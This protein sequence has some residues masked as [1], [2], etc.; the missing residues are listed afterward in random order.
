MSL[1]GPSLGAAVFG[2]P[3]IAILLAVGRLVSS[4]AV[5]TVGGRP[6]AAGEVLVGLGNSPDLARLRADADAE[7]DEFV[8]NGRVWHARSRSKNVQTLIAQL[9]RRR[10]VTYAEPNYLL[11]TTLQ[12]ND[13]QF[14]SLW[15]LLNVGQTIGGTPGV[16]G[17]DIHA[18]AAWDTAIGARTV[19]IGVVDTG[20]DYTHPDLAANVWSA[21]AKFTVTVGGQAIT[22]AAGTHGFNAITKTCDPLDDH[23]HGTHVS[24]TI[25][26]VGNNAVGVVGVNWLAN[27]IGLKFLNSGGAGNVADAVSAIEFGIQA[28]AAFG[29]AANIRV[30]SNSW[31]G[32]GFSQAM[33]D[34]IT[35]ANQND[36]LFVAAAGNSSSNN[37]TTPT[38]P[39]GYL[40]PN[41]VAV[42]ATDNQDGLASF[43]NYGAATVHL[44]APGVHVLS[45]VPGA[46]YN[47]FSG[48]S[49][50]TPHVSGSAALL[51]SRCTLDTPGVKALILNNVDPIP[52]L[53]GR[54]ITGG[55]LNLARAVSGCGPAGNVAP[56]VTLTA[57]AA[58]GSI[59]APG[60]LTLSANAFDVDGTVTQV[61]FYAGTSLIG[62]VT[63]PPYQ[64][65]WTNVLVGNYAIT[66][67][68]VDD[69]GATTTSAATNIRVL[70]G[71][72]STPFGGS[73]AVIPGLIEAENFNDGGEGVGYHDLSPGNAGGSYRATDVD[74]QPASDIGGGYTVSFIEP[75]EWLAYS[76]SVSTTT[77]YTLESRVA[78][79]GTGGVYHVEV[80]GFDVTGPI[81][82]PN[83]GGWQ[84]WQT[85]VTPGISMTAGP[86]LVRAVF[87]TKGSSGFFGNL[88]YM[89]W[90][91]PGL[92]TPP[93]VSLTSPANGATY[94]APATIP[95]TATANDVDGL[96]TQV[97]FYNGPSL[98][99]TT[100]L[101][102]YTLSWTT[103]P[104]GTYSLT[105]V[106]TDDV[107][108]TTASSPV[109][110]S[111]VPLPPSTP[112]GGIPAAIPGLVEAENFDDG[113]E[114]VAYHDLTSGNAGGKYRTTDVDIESTSDAG[115][116]YD[117]GWISAGE[118]LKYTVSAT[119]S[120]NYTLEARVASPGTG[121]SFH[122]EV[123]G[124]NA[125]GPLLVP[126]TG[127]WQTFQSITMAG[128]PISAG[129]HLLRVAFDTNGSS[130]YVAN[131]NY[132]RWTIPGVNTPPSVTLTSPAAGATYTAPATIPLAATASDIDGTVTQ[133]SFYNGTT[134]IG[135]DPAAPYAFSWMNVP[136]GTYQLTAVATDNS[137]A[138][139]TSIAVTVTVVTPPPSTPFGGTPAAI[140]GLIEAENFDDGGQGIAYN[141]TTAGNTGGK[142]R[143]TDVDIEASSDIGG[144]YDV[145]WVSAGEW[146]KY[147]VTASVAASYTLELRLAAPNTGGTLH[148]EADGV[149]VT[150]TVAV[151]NTGGWQSWQSINVAGIALNAGPHV[152]RLVFDTAGSSGSVANVNFMR[153][154]IPGVNVPPVVSLTAPVGGTSYNAP[155]SIPLSAT[156]YDPDGTIAQ[157][158]FFA[159]TTL[160]GTDV[161]PPYTLT[162]S[163][164][165]VGT[166]TLTAVA[167]D[168]SGASTTSNGATVQ[169]VVPPPSTPF[170]GLPAAV[171]G[172]IEAENFDDG[173]EGIA[174]HDTTGGN[175]GGKYRSTDVD[176]ESTSDV[177]GGYDLGWV[178]ASE[179]LKYTVS[180][181]TTATYTLELRVASP[182]TGGMCH[183][184]I[185]GVNVTGSIAAPNT[186]GWQTWTSVF[187]PGIPISAGPHVF[188]LV[189]DT[190]FG[191][192]NFMRWTSP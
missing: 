113:G 2:A 104:V 128:I 40:V 134:L 143:S 74:I 7:T 181:T 84:T 45:T 135:T 79:S 162:W 123:D 73:P 132:F 49:M 36:M 149:N 159:G 130:G 187:V 148:V 50:A 169:V 67:V 106:A 188:R 52:S 83:T 173:G 147:T 43:S 8:G 152:L 164:V 185:D 155:A 160:I 141:D 23:F 28:K 116:G 64:M 58:D 70:P 1:R 80:D 168:N 86:H 54:T 41:V 189:I 92:N 81:A 101:P 115:G 65:D 124:A 32:G 14:A 95:L 17:A 142:Y 102:P 59:S 151:P 186:G 10:D 24:G 34:E 191:N 3:A 131:L 120:G 182:G 48:T 29:A 176:I 190:N 96:V 88:N 154:R 66:A 98:I 51:L 172:L 166:Y 57:P 61:A 11:S 4:P 46:A 20:V 108:A 82:V 30:L 174:Y 112:F 6:V 18:T 19:L 163:S 100:T 167:V 138:S 105:A 25:G 165:P 144:G 13:P 75:G 161:A 110:V 175:Y 126:A 94:T 89:R 27:I 16:P 12:P 177:G 157:V 39:A 180:V 37:D 90:V 192:V 15:N 38:Y 78:S 170:G 136:A 171:P 121:G 153:W 117:V 118:W 44:G 62:A 129:S 119:V 103:V 53:A 5:E 33:F 139:T 109:T 31:A 72:T 179:W 140:P 93:T 156:A 71:P 9:S 55:R 22:C 107:G 77:Q 158:N 145:A 99:G 35:R 184:E 63:A 91:I 178:A 146:L 111:V 56:S 42:A 26:A 133:V 47:T 60:P 85:L 183:V 87:D 97:S 68:A 69:H 76:V 137:G 114:G 150:G 125:T 122:V 21:P 127:G